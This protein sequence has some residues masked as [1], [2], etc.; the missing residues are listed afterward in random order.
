MRMVYVSKVDAWVS[1]GGVMAQDKFVP[2]MIVM[3]SEL[4]DIAGM[5]QDGCG[6]DHLH[7]KPTE[8]NELL[9][10]GDLNEAFMH[11]VESLFGDEALDPSKYEGLY[12][13]PETKGE[14]GEEGTDTG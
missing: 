10:G 13:A 4:V 3:Q 14:G 7:E 8:T 9:S 11:S 1:I 6:H 5:H 2:L 12:I